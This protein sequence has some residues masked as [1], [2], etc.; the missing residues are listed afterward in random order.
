MHFYNIVYVS[1]NVSHRKYQKI[2]HLIGRGGLFGDLCVGES[3]PDYGNISRSQRREPS[4]QGPLIKCFRIF[5]IQS[6]CD[7]CQW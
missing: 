6:T 3:N 2:T 1:Q 7:L 5:R 4:G